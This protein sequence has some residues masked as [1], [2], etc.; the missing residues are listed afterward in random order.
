MATRWRILHKPLMH[1]LKVSTYIV[2]AIV[3]L[4][5]FILTEQ[6]R[7]TDMNE[8]NITAERNI[9]PQNDAE[10]PEQDLQDEQIYNDH[11]ENENEFVLDCQ[12][13]RQV[14]TNYFMTEVNAMR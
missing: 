1:K 5:N 9:S 3:C 13:Q 2:Q 10:I 14:L 8:H 12:R 7:G 6:L 11:M 4:H